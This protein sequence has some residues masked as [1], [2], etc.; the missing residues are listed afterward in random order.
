MNRYVAMLSVAS[1]TNVFAMRIDVNVRL[2][3]LE[4]FLEHL[5]AGDVLLGQGADGDPRDRDDGGFRGGEKR[6]G[7]HQND[8]AEN[9]GPMIAHGAPSIG[10]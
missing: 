8:E 6:G 7:T 5:C 4:Q 9:L 2:R 1:R 3:V 10:A